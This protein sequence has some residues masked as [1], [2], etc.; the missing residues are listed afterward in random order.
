M[1]EI[2]TTKNPSNDLN[3]VKLSLED[4]QKL[5]NT[6]TWLIQEDKKQNPLI[7]I[8]KKENKND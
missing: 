1:Q 8:I 4:N 2:V 7:Y 5:V 3:R 6:F